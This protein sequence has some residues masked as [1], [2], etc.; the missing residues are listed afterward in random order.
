M[1]KGNN[2]PQRSAAAAKDMSCREQRTLLRLLFS[3]A[4]L[5]LA[6]G[7]RI[8]APELMT[9]LQERFSRAVS[10][11][12]D[13]QEVFSAVGR[14]VS[15]GE[16]P[17]GWEEVYRAVFAPGEETAAPIAGRMEGEGN[18]GELLPCYSGNNTPSAACMT[19]RV[20]GFDFASPLTADVSSG[21]GIRTDPFT[22]REDFHYGMDLA[23]AEGVTVTA[24]ADG[25][26]RTVGDSTILGNYLIIDHANGYSTLYAHCSRITAAAEEEVALGDTVAEVGQSGSATGPHLHFELHRGSRYLNPVYYL[27]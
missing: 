24:F 25:T 15:G 1:R 21:F 27:A 26:V 2:R 4:I 9:S 17:G 20:L 19:Q 8:L 6:V 22:G 11:E 23:A 16:D 10:A 5:L 7:A 14:A 12:M 13:V 18:R 3:A